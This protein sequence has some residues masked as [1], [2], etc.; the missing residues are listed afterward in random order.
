[1]NENIKAQ[2]VKELTCKAMEANVL[3]LSADDARNAEAV[4]QAI[5]MLFNTIQKNVQA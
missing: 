3:R 2:I 1:M 4:G 5:A